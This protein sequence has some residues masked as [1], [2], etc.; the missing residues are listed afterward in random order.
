LG[1][2]Y[3]FETTVG[4]RDYLENEI[5]DICADGDYTKN[6]VEYIKLLLADYSI[7]NIDDQIFTHG[8]EII[9]WEPLPEY[10]ISVRVSLGYVPINEK[11][12]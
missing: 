4:V 8:E 12:K 6:S 2:I 5:S 11:N 7:A 1:D 9:K 10:K 3:F